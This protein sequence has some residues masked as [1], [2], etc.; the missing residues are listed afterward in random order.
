MYLKKEK[1][2]EKN[3]IRNINEHLEIFCDESDQE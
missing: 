3:K 2:K 1:K